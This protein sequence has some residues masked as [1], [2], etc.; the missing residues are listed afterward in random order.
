ML[1]R[2]DNI[3]RPSTPAACWSS[4]R[5]RLWASKIIKAKQ[6]AQKEGTHIS[7]RAHR[8]LLDEHRAAKAQMMAPAD[9]A[10]I[11]EKSSWLAGEPRPA[12]AFLQQ[13]GHFFLALFKT[14]REIPNDAVAA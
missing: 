1:C 12:Y 8:C 9:K 13:L 4:S 2:G 11:F 14:S 6:R 10:G 3:T 5:E 7:R